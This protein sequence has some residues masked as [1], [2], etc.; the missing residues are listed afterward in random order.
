MLCWWRTAYPAALSS[1]PPSAVW[2]GSC[3]RWLVSPPLSMCFRPEAAWHSF[4]GESSVCFTFSSTQSL[5]PIHSSQTLLHPL[6]FSSVHLTF[7]SPLAW[8]YHSPFSIRSFLTSSESLFLWMFVMDAALLLWWIVNGI[9]VSG[10]PAGEVRKIKGRGR[11][12]WC[13][14]AGIKTIT[15]WNW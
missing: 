1:P 10:P 11:W 5:V 8:I 13:C 7:F 9:C 4:S 6:N 15:A 2:F 14:G 12:V 3:E